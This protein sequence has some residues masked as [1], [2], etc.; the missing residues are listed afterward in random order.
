MA[1]DKPG[2]L[3]C[4]SVTRARFCELL[5]EESGIAVPP[6]ELFLLGLF[7]LLDAILD[8]SMKELMLK[9][10]IAA[11]IK[12]ALTEQ[13][14]PYAPFLESVVQYEKG[15]REA[16]LAALQRVQIAP[17]SV[18]DMYKESVHFAELLARR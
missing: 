15:E 14:G 5:A 17:A 9:L 16:C 10:P 8:I 12:N 13:E 4:L 3:I 6:S 2:E 18:Y 1:A 7:S 11:D